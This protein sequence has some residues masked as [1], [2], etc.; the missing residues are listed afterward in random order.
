MNGTLSCGG[1]K[2]SKKTLFARSST[3]FKN[4]NFFPN[5]TMHET[6][7]IKDCSLNAVELRDSY[8]TES[9]KMLFDT[10]AAYGGPSSHKKNRPCLMTPEGKGKPRR[11]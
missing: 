5:G 6:C 2:K 3:G 10:T 1:G 8:N 11:R 4:D 7:E 9:L